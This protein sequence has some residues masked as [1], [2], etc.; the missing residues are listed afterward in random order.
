MNTKNYILLI[1]VISIFAVGITYS[2]FAILAS[3]HRLL[4]TES[5]AMKSISSTISAPGVI[6]SENEAT[7]NFPIAGKLTYLPFKEGDKINQGQ[8]IAALDQR[9]IQENIQ[10]A[11]D[12]Y[13][14]QKI[15]Y[16][17]IN[18][19]N[20]DRALSD[21]GL[22]IAA[23]RQLET[24]VN[25]LDQAQVALQVQQIAQEQSVLVSPITGVVMHEDVTVPYVNITPTTTFLI[26]DPMAPVFRANV[27]ENDIDYVSVGSKVQ[28]QLNGLSGQTLLGIVE[29]IYPEKITATDGEQVYQVD[30]SSDALKNKGKLQQ[31]GTVLISSNTAQGTIL[32]P[33][34]LVLQH[35]YIW[36]VEDN[37]AIL[38]QI[39]LGKIHGTNIEVLRGLTENDSVI[40]NPEAIAAKQ[41]QIL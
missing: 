9:T 34:W 8:T 35:K 20:G 28:I 1:V 21:T 22:S 17:I 31:S 26:A 30:I 3:Q 27:S 14:N 38:K 23:R 15:S 13:A 6:R 12:A 4:Q 5:V 29:K 40:I 2:F 36:V 10:N 11:V 41:Y 7:L 18:D 19:F 32:V 25:T 24:A 39:E 37:K 33:V 16:N